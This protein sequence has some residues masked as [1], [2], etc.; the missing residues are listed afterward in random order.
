MPATSTTANS[1]TNFPKPAWSSGTI[2]PS[3]FFKVQLLSKEV[4]SL[5]VV[6]GSNPGAGL[7]FLCSFLLEIIGVGQIVRWSSCLSDRVYAAVFSD[8]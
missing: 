7:F 2:L 8:W 3:G 4:Y 5:G 6:P 1:P